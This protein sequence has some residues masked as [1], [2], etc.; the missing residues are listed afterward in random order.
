M[1]P[2]ILVTGANGFVGRSVC[3]ALARAGHN[4]RAAVR[5]ESRAVR[6]SGEVICVGALGRHTDWSAAVAGVDA[7]I[8]L[9]ARVHVMNETAADPLSAFRAVNVDATQALAEAA[10]QHG[11]QRVVYV[12]SIKVNGE[13][14]STQAFT[15]DDTPQPQD[16]YGVSKWEAEALLCRLAE[17]GGMEVTVV[18]P[19]LVYGPGVGGNFRRLLTVI[20]HGIPLPLA[21]VKNRRSMV[22]NGNLAAALIMCATHPTAANKTYLVSDGEDLSTPEL[23]R[24]LGNMIGKQA[25]LLRCPPS[26]LQVGANLI[27]KGDEISR[28]T[29]SLEVDSSRL[30][31]D[32]DWSPP[33]SMDQGLADT[34]LWFVAEQRRLRA[35]G[36]SSVRPD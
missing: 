9:A 4:L 27:G 36:V 8:H 5:D 24:R 31:T 19:P 17:R 6:L 15:P 20:A 16:P 26:L 34:A 10:V 30:G 2:R 1:P 7:V 21:S 33:F 29:A 3:A 12:S 32:L 14:T 25:R 23:M 22:Y 35:N 28:L 18:R 13:V 11:V